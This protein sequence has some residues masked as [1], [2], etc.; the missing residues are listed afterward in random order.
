MSTKPRAKKELV[1]V[2]VF[3]QWNEKGATEFGKK[4]ESFAG[5]GLKL[6]SLSN[7][8]VNV[9]PHG[10][11]ETFLTDHWRACFKGEGNDTPIQHGQ[12]VSLLGRIEK[13]G[14][15]FIKIENLYTFDGQKG[16]VAGQGE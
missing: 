11:E 9:Y 1:G 4:L 15:D 10:F 2:D 14:L 5:D 8:G 12:I 6:I 16:F 3:L 13:G 7:R